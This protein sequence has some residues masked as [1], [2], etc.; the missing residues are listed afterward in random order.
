MNQDLAIQVENLSKAY[1]LGQFNTGALSGDLS[2]LWALMRGKEDPFLLVGEKNV[3]GKV[4]NS[5]V[6]WSLKDINFELKK[7]ESVG[8]IGKNGAGKSTLLKILSRVTGPTKGRVNLRGRVAS[9]LEVG[10]GFHPELTGRENIFLNGAILGMRKNEIKKQ[11]DAIVDFSGVAR[12]IDTPSKR[13]SSGMKVRLGFAVAAHLNSQILIVDEVLAVGDAEFRDKCINKM[14]DIGKSEGRTILFVSHNMGSVRALC[15]RSILLEDGG[16][17]NIG[18]TDEIIDEYLGSNTDGTGE[19]VL[20]RN[21]KNHFHIEKVILKGGDG[22]T[23]ST[24]GYGEDLLVELHVDSE[25]NIQGP[26]LNLAINSKRG[27]ISLASNLID[28]F[29]PEMIPEGKSVITCKFD[30]MP[31]LPSEYHLSFWARSADTREKVYHSEEIATFRI[32]DLLSD[33]GFGPVAD[34]WIKNPISP[35]VPYTWGYANGSSHTFHIN[36]YVKG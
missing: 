1:R 3:R 29:C 13:Y 4:G 16:V 15:S 5:K 20:N 34:N 12:Y 25:R 27:A 22:K 18:P 24:F 26:H 10:T 36:N 19:Y 31:F 8:I 2:R 30:K 7:G 32:D 35:V 17:K 23:K 11:F 9:L 14:D 33:L 6:V 28:G 21:S